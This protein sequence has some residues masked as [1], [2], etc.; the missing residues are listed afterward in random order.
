MV[1]ELLFIEHELVLI[2]YLFICLLILGKKDRASTGGCT[3]Q[4]SMF[5]TGS[6]G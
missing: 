5:P 3:S 1:V 2:V 6:L 4:S